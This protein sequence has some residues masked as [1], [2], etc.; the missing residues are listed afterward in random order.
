MLAGAPPVM[1][2]VRRL[3]RSVGAARIRRFALTFMK[4]NQPKTG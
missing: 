2:L 3:M 1:K 4:A